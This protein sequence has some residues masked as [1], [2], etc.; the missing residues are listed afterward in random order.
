MM[1]CGG[2]RGMAGSIALSSIAALHT[3]SGLVSTAVPDRCLETVASFHPCVM[4]IPLADDLQ[5]HFA[6]G[7][8]DELASRL[9]GLDAIGCGPGMTT[10]DGSM[11]I[12][13]RLIE[14]TKL[15][16]VFDADAINCLAK[17]QW[18]KGDPISSS[19]SRSGKSRSN[20]G[21]AN[22]IVLTPHP[23]E[24]GRL[25]GI[26]TKNRDLQIEAAQKLAA[27]HHVT[28]VVKGGPTVVVDATRTWINSTGNPGMA[29]A[30]SGDVLT[31]VITSLMGQGLSPWDAA[32]LGVW[33]HGAAGDRA[34][35][36]YGQPGMSA[37]ELLSELPK[38]IAAFDS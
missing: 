31:G 3:G 9:D 16:R 14:P 24:L 25:A 22:N 2:S 26:D 23:G 4:T 36:E 33:I 11:Q 5:G 38:V 17:M 21:E 32:R 20:N 29:T 8:V 28:I 13:R 18:A 6:V 27:H 19:K 1:L 34:A 12:V 15:A 30:G 7:A 10:N 35:A 37:Y